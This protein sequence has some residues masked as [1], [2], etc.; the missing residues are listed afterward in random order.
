[1]SKLTEELLS[2]EACRGEKHL[3]PARRLKAAVPEV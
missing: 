1:M 2:C 3:V